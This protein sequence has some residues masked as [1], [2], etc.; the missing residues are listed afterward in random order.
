MQV[1]ISSNCQAQTNKTL[2]VSG[3]EPVVIDATYPGTPSFSINDTQLVGAASYGFEGWLGKC[4]YDDVLLE[5]R[6]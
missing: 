6:Y 2:T 3:W 1:S 5:R 4:I